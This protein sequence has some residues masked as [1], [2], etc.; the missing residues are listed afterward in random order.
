MEAKLSKLEYMVKLFYI[1]CISTVYEKYF[2]YA[3]LIA[4][5]FTTRYIPEV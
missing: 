2:G 3:I 1:D 5:F 4:R